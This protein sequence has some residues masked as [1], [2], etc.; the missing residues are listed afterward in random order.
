MVFSDGVKV[1]S[2]RDFTGG[3]RYVPEDTTMLDAHGERVHKPKRAKVGT[4]NG[5]T[6]YACHRCGHAW[7]P[8]LSAIN[9]GSKKGQAQCECS[10]WVK[11]P[12]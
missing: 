2:G 9:Q 4:G 12:A 8:D 6:R 5:P 11:P 3:Y 10:T 1:S 7:N